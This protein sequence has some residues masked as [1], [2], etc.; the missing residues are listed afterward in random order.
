[1]IEKTS[2]VFKRSSVTRRLINKMIEEA[3]KNNVG[4]VNRK[5]HKN[6]TRP[7]MRAVLTRDWM[8]AKIYIIL[9]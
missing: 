2:P 1:M 4:L 3:G 6:L 8:Y 5:V 9:I 7:L